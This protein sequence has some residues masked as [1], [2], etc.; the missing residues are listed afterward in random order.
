[1]HLNKRKY[2]S[3]SQTFNFSAFQRNFYSATML[4]NCVLLYFQLVFY[5]LIT[6][7]SAIFQPPTL[8]KLYVRKNDSSVYHTMYILCTICL[9][10]DINV[11]KQYSKVIF[12]TSFKP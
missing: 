8:H 5:T 4:I 12:T 10:E 1:M 7:Y 3:S 6:A 9:T 2:R 11:A